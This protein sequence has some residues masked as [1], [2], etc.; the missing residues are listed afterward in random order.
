MMLHPVKIMYLRRMIA[1]ENC[2][3]LF[4]LLSKREFDYS[5]AA[6]LRIIIDD[7]T[8]HTTHTVYMRNEDTVRD[9]SCL[10]VHFH[11]IF[12]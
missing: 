3:A 11:F 12:I 9:V 8:T 10:F 6:P 5:E 1:G 4:Y 7:T 2:C